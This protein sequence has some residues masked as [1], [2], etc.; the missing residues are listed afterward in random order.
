[1]AEDDFEIKEI[2]DY[3]GGNP[4]ESFSQSALV[5]S[6]I[7]KALEKGSEEMREGYWNTKFDRMGNAH[8]TW[9]PDARKVFIETVE[10][11]EMIMDRDLDDT[12]K[13]ELKTISDGL[14]TKWDSYC[15]AEKKD[16][17]IANVLLKKKWQ[18]EGAY[19]REDFLSKALPY[20]YEYIQDEVKT[21]REKIKAFTRLVKRLNNY[22]EEI[23]EA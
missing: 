18:G 7:R 14:K 4:G 17:E 2:D 9:I 11:V 1:M 13:T 20:A 3:Y 10:S 22:R 5:M 8:R 21:A 12:A 23:Y 15:E 16:W 19:F 6:A